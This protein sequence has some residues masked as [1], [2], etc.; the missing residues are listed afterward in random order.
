MFVVRVAPPHGLRPAKTAAHEQILRI[1]IQPLVAAHCLR[2]FHGFIFNRGD[3][4]I[5]INKRDV[6]MFVEGVSQQLQRV[7]AVAVVKTAD[8][9]GT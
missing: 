7:N 2:G 3:Q 4:A 8:Q 9:T 5:G 6:G 1:E